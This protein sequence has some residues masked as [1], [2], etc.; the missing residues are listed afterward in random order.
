MSGA[1][2][3]RTQRHS[4]ALGRAGCRWNGAARGRQFAIYGGARCCSSIDAL[5]KRWDWRKIE[6]VENDVGV[7]FARAAS[8]IRRIS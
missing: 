3:F 4:A 1:K 6:I 7:G 8:S 5:A 2:A